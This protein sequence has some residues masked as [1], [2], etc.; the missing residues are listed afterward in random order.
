MNAASDLEAA[1]AALIA[2]CRGGFAQGHG[3][4]LALFLAGLAGGFTHCATMC[5]PFVLG[6]VAAGGG[7]AGTGRRRRLLAAAL[8][9]YHLGR[10]TTYAALG[11]IAAS[12]TAMLSRFA[13]AAL[14]AVPLL[15]LAA[16]L[17]TTQ[18]LGL[19]L[20]RLAGG[21]FGRL[22]RAIGGIAA[23]LHQRSLAGR[24][25]LGVLLGFLPCGLLYAAL[26]AASATASGVQGAAAMAAFAAGTAPAL[27]VVGFAGHGLARHG[28]RLLR[29]AAILLLVANAGTLGVVAL[30]AAP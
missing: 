2:L 28:G 24:Y 25:A 13:D 19:A 12:G 29:F 18:A 26:A 30:S 7:P 15:L 3:P 8:L 22:A 14:V 1:L 10:I 27:M 23:A 21:L 16:A 5:G 11:A 20:P 4:I 9:P 6:Q 17:M